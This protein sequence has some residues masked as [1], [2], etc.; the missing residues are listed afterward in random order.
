MPT[1]MFTPLEHGHARITE[2]TKSE[3]AVL[4]LGSAIDLLHKQMWQWTPERYGA[5]MS[6]TIGKT[7]YRSY[8]KG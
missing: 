3:P 6:L 2:Q 8:C 1:S 7:I 4:D 5:Y